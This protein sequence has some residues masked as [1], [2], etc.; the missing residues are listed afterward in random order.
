MGLVLDWCWSERKRTG[1]IELG[2]RQCLCLNEAST[3][4]EKTK[5]NKNLNTP[6]IP[7]Y[8]QKNPLFITSK[9]LIIN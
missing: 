1:Y 2:V 4:K 3:K 9:K 8:Q 6:K 5:Q 7:F